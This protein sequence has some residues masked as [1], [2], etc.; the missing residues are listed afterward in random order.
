MWD[1][2]WWVTFIGAWTISS[3]SLAFLLGKM[4]ALSKRA[5]GAT[6]SIRRVNVKRVRQRGNVSSNPD[7][8]RQHHSATRLGRARVFER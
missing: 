3:V 5:N 1:I 2:P 7:F 8:H 4:M 6:K